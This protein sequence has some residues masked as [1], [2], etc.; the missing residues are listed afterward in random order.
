MS[1]KNYIY[2]KNENIKKRYESFLSSQNKPMISLN[3]EIAKY[4]FVNTGKAS[5]SIKFTLKRLG[6]NPVILRRIAI[7]S[8]EAEINVTSHTEGGKVIGNIFQDCVQTL[9]IDNGPGIDDIE[10]CMQ[11]GYSTAKEIVREMGFGAGLGLPNIKKNA[12][13]LKITSNIND[14]TELEILIFFQENG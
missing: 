13:V 7:A 12:D 6:V 5:S 2:F 10:K 4:D 1:A 3:F 8:Y 11:P 14:H 9:F